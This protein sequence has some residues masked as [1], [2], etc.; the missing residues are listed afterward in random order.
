[1]A[2]LGSVDTSLGTIE[3][4][5]CRGTRGG[6]SQRVSYASVEES[7]AMHEKTVK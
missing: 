4:K 3:L 7:G 6:P 5:I 2:P 1:M